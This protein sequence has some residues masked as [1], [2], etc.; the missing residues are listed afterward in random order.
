MIEFFL[1]LF[2]GT[3]ACYDLHSR[4]IPNEVV[5]A[6]IVAGFF[7]NGLLSEE[8][9]GLGILNSLGGLGVGLLLLLPLYLLHAMGAGDIKL[10]AMSGAFLGA[11][12][13][14][15]AFIY[16]LL[17]GGLLAIVMAC[18]HLGQDR[19]FSK[20]KKTF[21]TVPLVRPT[22]R[23][24]AIGSRLEKRVTLPYGV[25]IAVGT[26]VYLLNHHSVGSG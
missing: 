23:S 7:L 14:T 6:G 9:G 17:V 19:L 11:R 22:L 3:A 2:L 1:L 25:A 12:G 10:M 15:G 26:A 21:P 20:R 18:H 5:S 24:E 13:V 8:M 16:V 4:R